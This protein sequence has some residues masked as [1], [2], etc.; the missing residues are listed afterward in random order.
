[1]T[2]LSPWF[3]L[4]ALAAAIPIALHLFQRRPERVIPFAAIR[5]LQRVPAEE[6]QRRRIRD[7]LLLALRASMLVLLALAFAQPYLPAAAASAPV[8]LVLVDVSASMTAPGRFA[9][10]QALAHAAIDEAAAGDVIG[11]GAFAADLDLVAPISA[12]REA[13]HA[14]VRA[15]SPD[16]RA[17]RYGAALAAAG[18][19]VA[20]RRGRLVVV[21]DLQESGWQGDSG[22]RLPAGVGVDVREVAP[23]PSNVAITG[24]RVEGNEAIAEVAH[25]GA[26]SITGHVAFTI[27]AQPV[28]GTAVVLPAEGRAE[29]RARLNP[30]MQGILAATVTDRQGIA[31]DNARY[32]VLGDAGAISVLVVTAA[33]QADEW[34]YLQR[35]LAVSPGAAGFRSRVTSG[36]ALAGLKPRELG[37]VDAIVLMTTRGMSEAARATIRSFLERGGGLLIAAGPSVDAQALAALDDVDAAAWGNVVDGTATLI[38]NDDRHPIFRAFRGA[39]TLGNVT[40]RRVMPLS[41][42][43]GSRVLAT[44]ADGEAALVERSLGAARVLAF[45]SDLDDRWSDLPLHP[46][47]VPFV[48]ETVRY[49]AGDR[50]RRAEVL[51]GDVPGLPATAG[52]ARIANRPV[53]VNVDPR[54]S[55][56]ARTTVAAFQSRVDDVR[57]VDG[58]TAKADVDA[59]GSRLWQW[60]LLSMLLASVLEGVLGRRAVA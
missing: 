42:A 57:T 22:H 19:V 33:G 9:E 51:A 26:D 27:D 3:L 10:A 31:A 37:D 23:L 60:A 12:D 8:T 30:A 13:A 7:L 21:T 46:S 24:L 36:P 55:D 52:V 49:L 58:V 45:A 39:A 17:T 20:G 59:G 54:E 16:A 1:M 53:A 40:F 6:A 43:P 38:A 41:P 4:G 50:V 29:A 14:A 11:V 56:P 2:F 25:H 35:A 34:F 18:E 47:F 32:A 28:G 15:L 44:F 5:F 48:H